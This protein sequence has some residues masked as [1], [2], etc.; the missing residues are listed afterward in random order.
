[1][2]NGAARGRAGSSNLDLLI[3]TRIN[4]TFGQKGFNAKPPR[5][6]VAKLFI[7]GLYV[8]YVMDVAKYVLRVLLPNTEHAIRINISSPVLYTTKKAIGV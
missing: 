5:R 3:L 2:P 1:M 8:I 4:R 7:N 6:K